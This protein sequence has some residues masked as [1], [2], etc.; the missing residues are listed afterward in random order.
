MLPVYNDDCDLRDEM[1][2]YA[3]QKKSLNDR[4]GKH[5]RHKRELKN[6]M[7]KGIDKGYMSGQM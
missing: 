3:S 1:N 6:A 2:D 7:L 5:E 4:A